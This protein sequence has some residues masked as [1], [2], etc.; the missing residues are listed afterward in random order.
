MKNVNQTARTKFNKRAM[1]ITLVLT[2]LFL[3]MFGFGIYC[4]VTDTIPV[5]GS[6]STK[7]MQTF[8]SFCIYRGLTNAAICFAI[9]IFYFRVHNIDDF[10]TQSGSYEIRWLA[11]AF[12]GI[13]VVNV[14]LRIFIPDAF[15][16][17]HALVFL[18]IICFLVFKLDNMLANK[19][20]M[21]I[22]SEGG[23][24]R[25]GDMGVVEFLDFV[26]KLFKGS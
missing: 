2:V 8:I 12:L 11:F 1:G 25:L 10:V 19:V 16:P 6:V 21:Y 4:L 26:A 18:A 14:I 5:V 7:F 20:D 13:W 22:N 24:R 23:S 9:F 3:V 17:P 15:M